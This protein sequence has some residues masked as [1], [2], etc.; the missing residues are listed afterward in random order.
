MPATAT[1]SAFEAEIRAHYA[2]DAWK[3]REKVVLCVVEKAALNGN[4]KN[5]HHILVEVAYQ[6]VYHDLQDWQSLYVFAVSLPLAALGG[7]TE[8]QT[9]N[10]PGEK[11]VY[12]WTGV[13]KA[14]TSSGQRQSF[15]YCV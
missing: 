2:G 11:V 7:R 6:S 15:S 4:D 10:K 12:D 5:H 13:Y 9:Q 8:R 3:G 1:L 14:P